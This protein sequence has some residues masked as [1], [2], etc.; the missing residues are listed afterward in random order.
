MS[1]AA[2]ERGNKTGVQAQRKVRKGV[3]MGKQDG[4]GE[5]EFVCLGR[6]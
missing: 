4:G 3:K 1:E 6:V 2:R 5:K